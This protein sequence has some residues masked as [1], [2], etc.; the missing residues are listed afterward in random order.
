ME[1]SEAARRRADQ[2]NGKQEKVKKTNDETLHRKLNIK[3]HKPH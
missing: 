2:Y 3:Q 1:Q